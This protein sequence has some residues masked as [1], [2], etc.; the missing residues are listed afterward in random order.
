MAWA[1]PARNT[2][3]TPAMCAATSFRGDTLAS[4]RAGV[5]ITSSRTPA[6]FAGIA[7]IST[8]AGDVYAHAGERTHYLAHAVL[9]KAAQGVLQLPLVEGSDPVRGLPQSAHEG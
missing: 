2:R 1:P 6:T 4:G 8:L 7:V 3:S 5:A 9:V